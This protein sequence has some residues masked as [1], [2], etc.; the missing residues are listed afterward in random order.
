M[1]IVVSPKGVSLLLRCLPLPLRL[2]ALVFALAALS[3][4]ALGCGEDA[5]AGDAAEK[6]DAMLRDAAGPRSDVPDG[7]SV[8][9]GDPCAGIDCATMPDPVCVGEATLRTFT[10]P[11][12]CVGGV[13]QFSHHDAPC[14]D[15]CY[16]AEVNPTGDPIGGGSGY[17]A[18]IG[19]SQAKVAVKTAQELLA[20]L[21]G[22]V[23]GDVVYV[24][25]DAA[26]DLTGETKLAIPAGVI[27]ASG[28][29][30]GTSRGG[31]IF[32]DSYPYPLFVAQGAKIRLTGLRLRGPNP[33]VGD[34]HYDIIKHS[35]LLSTTHGDIEVDNCEIWA[36]GTNAIS[37]G[38]GATKAKIHHN[39]I[40]HTRRAGLGYGVVLNQADALI[41]G[42]LFDAC[43]HFIAG[44][45]RFG[46]SYIARYN[47]IL[48]H[49]N[50]HNFDMH[51]ARDFDKYHTKAIWRLDEGKGG[52]A[53]DSSIGYYH[54]LNPCT[55]ENMDLNTSWVSGRVGTALRFDGVNDHLA[56]GKNKSLTSSQGTVYFWMKMNALGQSAD[57]FSLVDAVSSSALVV[58][59]DSKNRIGLVVRSHGSDVVNSVST[60]VITDTQFHHVAITQD[61]KGAVIYL[62]G[63]ASPLSG[64][65]SGAWS[66]HLILTESLIGGGAGGYFSG[67]FDEVRVYDRALEAGEVVAHFQGNADIA[68]NTIRIVHNTF[69]GVDQAAIIIRGRPADGAWIEDNWFYSADPA[70][71]LRQVNAQG[72]FHVSHNYFGEKP[73]LGTVLPVALGHG[74]PQ[75]GAA[76]LKVVF[77][78]SESVSPTPG[79]AIAA[80]SWDFG[81]GDRA[82]T[83]QVT[84]VFSEAGAYLVRLRA[85]DTLGAPASQLIP[86]VATPAADGRYRLNFWVKDSYAGDRKGYYAKQALIDD[87]V[88]WQ[89]DVATAQ[90]WEH[91]SVDVSAAVVG[92][93]RVTVAFRLA[94]TQAVSHEE[95]IEIVAYWDDVALFGGDVKDG[96]FEKRSGWAYREVGASSWSGGYHSQVPH[97]GDASFMLLHPYKAACPQGSYAEASQIVG[98]QSKDVLGEWRFDEGAGLVARDRSMYGNDLKLVQMDSQTAWAQGV[99]SRAILFDGKDDYL[100]DANPSGSLVSAKGTLSLWVKTFVTQRT[101]GLFEVADAGG[102]NALRLGLHSG[103]RPAVTIQRG[104]SLVV[105][106][107]AKAGIADGHYHHLV[108][109]QDGAQVILYV[110]GAVVATT[111]TNGIAWSQ[112]I[113]PARLIVGGGASARFQGALDEV[114]VLATAM[115]PKAVSAAYDARRIVAR[116]HFDEGQGVKA[117]DSGE[118]HHDGTLEGMNG[119]TSWVTGKAGKA[120]EFDGKDDYVA[121]G[122][123]AGLASPQGTIELWLKTDRFDVNMDLLNLF[124]D[125]YENFLLIRRDASNRIL[126]L[127]ERSDKAVVSVVSGTRVRDG[128]FHH[129]AITQDGFGVRIYVDGEDAGAQGTNSD[130][131]T[132][133]LIPQGVWGGR[134]H[135][136]YFRGVLDEI[137]IYARALRVDEIAAHAGL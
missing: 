32:S 95:L 41:E 8:S 4:S 130:A 31:L 19:A 9:D 58:R 86:I 110:D 65:N 92:K 12:S 126:V 50:G 99:M 80:M 89:E 48:G 54:A 40:H 13:C 136:S 49:G 109:T 127:I 82:S 118:G 115:A 23:S 101:Q 112:G 64:V 72:N 119:A 29:G 67:I 100:E 16:G 6:G 87:K 57:L 121:V 79:R 128:A 30:R 134:G 63:K 51:G 88:V 132:G 108:A 66:D 96:D 26:I 37:L 94:N 25:D 76:K 53:K 55:L 2:P 85:S 46:T 35:G 5:P 38:K 70:R 52:E 47:V 44:T 98:V 131:W 129:V 102:A 124:Q 56:C 3:L 15:C 81:E 74:T 84:H 120:L 97:S 18:V 1:P 60:A 34:H 105:D 7:G 22:S 59:V 71:A 78:G 122:G 62:D 123:G 106:V 90:G 137:A 83:R 107:V 69:R 43:R 103:G 10:G 116:W 42:N 114:Q 28:R 117:G 14:T 24:D 36:W 11:G 125:G 21:K 113:V 75:R 104:G 73:P 77:D 135:W 133:G 27:L 68:G 39:Y 93:D 91:I 111:G 61:G 33:D 20:A 45:G 17:R